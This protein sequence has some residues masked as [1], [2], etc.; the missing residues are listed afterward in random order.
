ML[1]A[2]SAPLFFIALASGKGMVPW[3]HQTLPAGNEPPLAESVYT[4]KSGVWIATGTT[5]YA[6]DPSGSLVHAEAWNAAPSGMRYAGTWS[7]D[8][9]YGPD[10]LLTGIREQVRLESGWRDT[11][12]NPLEV[13]REY[14]AAGG[15]KVELVLDWFDGRIIFGSRLQRAYDGSGREISRTESAY[16]AGAW[17]ALVRTEITYD[18][19]GR[20]LS[21]I[22]DGGYRQVYT[23]DA[24]G[25]PLTVVRSDRQ[26]AGEWKIEEAESREYDAEGRLA[27][28]TVR[29][30]IP[31]MTGSLD[32]ADK[33][34]HTYPSPSVHEMSGWRRADN[35]RWDRVNLYRERLDGAGNPVE[36][37]DYALS[38]SGPAE[39]S[40]WIFGFDARKNPS[41]QEE[42]SKDGDRW[43]LVSR[44]H[45]EFDAGDRLVAG[46]TETFNEAGIGS[47]RS[48]G[49]R[50]DTR[51][52][53][54]EAT[55]LNA[56]SD[57]IPDAGEKISYAYGAPSALGRLP[58][59]TRAFP[60]KGLQFQGNGF[61]ILGESPARSLSGR[62]ATPR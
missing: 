59:R 17:N 61:L 42:Y 48:Y 20:I 12:R 28:V 31:E 4:W 45:R 49:Y 5:A 14:R 43:I 19:A 11:V 24:K 38:D 40:K 58:A 29:R 21:E 8:F 54:L 50:F 46:F 22:S 7:W 33:Y 35:G 34:L 36:R 18:A 3:G 39:S 15:E 53:L 9:A 27:S 26:G 23:Y 2:L 16:N 37:I 1:K 25:N 55:Y 44:G 6:Y 52:N 13:R 51:G 56:S 47:R 32:S 10:F 62:R 57:G 41:E 30:R 60:R